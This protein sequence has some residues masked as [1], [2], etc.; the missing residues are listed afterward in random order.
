M[1]KSVEWGEFRIGDLFEIGTGSLLSNSELVNGKI[2]RISA[3]SNNNGVIGYFNTEILSN[4]RHFEN[5]ISVN[6]FGTEG[7]IFYHP[8]KASIEMKVHTLKIP[9]VE[10]NLKT[11]KFIVTALKLALNGFGYGNQLSSSKLKELELNIKL[12]VKNGKIN[13]SFIEKFISE[14]EAY[15]VATNLTDYTLNDK[16][17]AVLNN[18]KDIKWQIFNLEK[19]F[20]KS[21][22]GKRLKS[23]DRVLGD[24][25]FVTAGETNEGI[26]AFIGN[27]VTIFS[28]NT[29]TIDMFGSAKYRNYKYGADDHIA[30]VHTEKLAKYSAL[31]VTT[32][33][34]KS[35]YNGQFDYSR[36][37]YAKDADELN[38]SLPAKNNKPDF[39]MMNI[40][41]SA[42]QKLVI[43]DVVLYADRKIAITKSIIG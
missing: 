4:A 30:V 34:H 17:K 10:L 14:L 18:F 2:P 7:G 38:I 41:I 31:F 40:F 35:S 21:T 20:G 43:K 12:P 22:R 37:F 42:I 32:S 19:L 33:I 25:P 9:N 23:F 29:T 11:G 26:S 16:E 3:K 27:D 36:N 5:F 28:E 24:L 13:F 1:L 39:E 8:Y 15:L 6:F